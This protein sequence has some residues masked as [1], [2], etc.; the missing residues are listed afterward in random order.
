[1]PIKSTGRKCVVCKT[2][3]VVMHTSHEYHGPLMMNID[4]SARQQ[5]TEVTRY[6]CD[7]CGV[8][9][10]QPP[11]ASCPNCGHVVKNL[12]ERLSQCQN[13]ESYYKL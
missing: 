12:T 8:L 6:Y 3:D 7:C 9:Y 4:L 10:H 5:M 13:C 2:G 11:N 1:M